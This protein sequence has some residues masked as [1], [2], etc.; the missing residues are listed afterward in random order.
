MIRRGLPSHPLLCVDPRAPIGLHTLIRQQLFEA[1]VGGAFVPAQPSRGL[2][3]QLGVARNTV[4][5]ACQQLIAE[6]HL[7]ARERSG[8]YVNVICSE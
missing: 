4:V 7:V 3:R 1:I 5:L 8:I 6:G 2:A